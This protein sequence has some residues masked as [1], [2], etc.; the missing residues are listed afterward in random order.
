MDVSKR[1]KGRRNCGESHQEAAV[2]ETRE[3][4]GYQCQIYPVT[5]STRA[6]TEIG[7]DIPDEAREFPDLTESFMLTI[8]ETAE[9]HVKLI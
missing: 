1:P 5:M 7:H 3:D 8:R 9:S 2:R 4:T 6:K